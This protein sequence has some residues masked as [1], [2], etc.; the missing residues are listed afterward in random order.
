MPQSYR[1]HA[2]HPK[3]TYAAAIFA[4][5]AVTLLTKAWLEGRN[6]PLLPA[7]FALALAVTVLV[8]ISRWYIV[9]LQN[10]IIRLE[11]QVRLRQVLPPAQQARI[12]QLT[13]TQ[14]VGLR[15]ASDAELPALVERTVVENLSRDQIKQ[16]IRD[17]QD[18]AFRT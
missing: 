9:S 2:H 3:A 4:G 12:A 13:M 1:S 5:I 14:L 10:R 6:T 16:S 7:T 8:G 18:D 17:W 11:M 15:F